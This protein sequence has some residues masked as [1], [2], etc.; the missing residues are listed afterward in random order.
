MP[1]NRRRRHHDRGAISALAAVLFG[2][3]VLLGMA[4]LVVDVGLL[5]TERA[6][7][8][9][10]ADAA[11]VEVAQICATSAVA[12]CAPAVTGPVAAQYARDNAANGEADGERLRR[13]RRRCR[14]ARRRRRG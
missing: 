9:N 12:D 8:Q 6:Q 4:A 13:R 7:L 3:G 10:G 1:L 2:S 5:Y 11:A 14:P